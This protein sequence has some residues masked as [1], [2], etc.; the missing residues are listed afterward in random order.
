MGLLRSA[1]MLWLCSVISSSC[2]G[3]RAL[4]PCEAQEAKDDAVGIRQGRNSVEKPSG[5]LKRIGRS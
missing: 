5:L 2:A 4:R 3:G 1:S